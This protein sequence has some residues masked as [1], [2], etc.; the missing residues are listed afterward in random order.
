MD[1]AST[2]RNA[3][4]ACVNQLYGVMLRNFVPVPPGS[5]GYF[6]GIGPNG[7]GIAIETDVTHSTWG[8]A[9]TILPPSGPSAGRTPLSTAPY[10]TNY[11]ATGY[12]YPSNQIHEIAH[13]L[14]QIIS[15]SI[16]GSSEA[17]ADRLMNCITKF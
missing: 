1:A 17:S 8:L 10:Q 3:L 14:D 16:F 15:G 6:L 4:S 12:E 11:V 13:S 2:D 7:T 5:N 9:L